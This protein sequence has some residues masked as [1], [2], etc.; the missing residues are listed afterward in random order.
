VAPKNDVT[1][2]VSTGDEVVVVTL[3]RSE[4]LIL[5][6][7]LVKQKSLNWI[8]KYARNVLF[9]FAGGIIAIIALY[10]NVINWIKVILNT[11]S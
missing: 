2:S 1:E 3:P 9:V 7:M 10:D 6:D 4:Y 8:S 5:R 11:Q